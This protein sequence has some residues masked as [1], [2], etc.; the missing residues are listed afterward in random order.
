MERQDGVVQKGL[1]VSSIKETMEILWLQEH[2]MIQ[3]AEESLTRLYRVDCNRREENA[4]H[5][6]GKTWKN[7]GNIQRSSKIS[8]EDEKEGA[9]QHYE[10]AKRV[11]NTDCN[12]LEIWGL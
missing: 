1:Q 3:V 4:M 5:F 9:F 2:R 6:I 7:L 11:E 8:L 10:A 12:A